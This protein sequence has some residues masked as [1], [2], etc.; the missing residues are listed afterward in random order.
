MPLSD[1][2]VQLRRVSESHWTRRNLLNVSFAKLKDP[3]KEEY[4]NLLT[5]GE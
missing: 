1:T 3:T 5:L 4:D 2:L